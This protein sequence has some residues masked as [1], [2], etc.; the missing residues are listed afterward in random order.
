M[1][2][3]VLE[4]KEIPAKYKIKLSGDGAKMSRITGFIIISFSILNEGEAVLSSKGDSLIHFMII[5]WLLV[6]SS[7][8]IATIYTSLHHSRKSHGCSYQRERIL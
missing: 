1:N 8:Y 5:M 2:K 7:C 6:I 4:G 3:C